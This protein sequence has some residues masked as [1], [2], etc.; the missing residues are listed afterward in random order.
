MTEFLTEQKPNNGPE[1]LS[2]KGYLF[3]VIGVSLII[4][5]LAGGVAGFFSASFFSASLAEW[6][7]NPLGLAKKIVSRPLN[8]NN[9]NSNVNGQITPPPAVQEEE[10][11]TTAAV[12]KVSPAVVSIVVTK[13]VRQYYNVSGPNSLFDDFF[14]SP[15]DNFFN[16]SQPT[17]PGQTEKKK[18]GGG[19]GFIISSDGLIVTN[20]HV[21]ADTEAEYSIIRSDGKTYPAQVVARDPV[22]DLAFLKI[23]GDN[24]P[25]AVL[26]DSAKL[27]VGQTVIAIGFALGEYSNTVTKGIISGIGRDIV[28]SGGG[29]ASEKLEG[30]IQTDAAIN[31]G[32]SGGPLINLAGEVIGINTAI[33]QSGQLI[34]F[35]IPVNNIKQVVK[36][37]KEKGKIVRAYLGVRYSV[38]TKELAQKNN[39][40]Y[41]YGALVVRGQA[42]G[43][44]A[45]IPASPADKAGLEENDIILQVDGVKLD[46]NKSLAQEVA[47]HQPGDKLNL[48][49]AHDGQE[50]IVQ[51]TLEEYPN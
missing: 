41:D 50:K 49:V 3:L 31:P 29:V 48:K 26:G 9:Q 27:K 12:A 33:N 42:S 18:I 35:A 14:N 15:F 11:S 40:K 20:K 6:L 23:A 47:K 8:L 43:E 4:G 21:V 16:Q 37:V 10:N 5:G 2:V 19:T 51:V 32:N 24:L 28:A 17:V 25:T 38:I 46:E 36:T 7:N 45:V 30:V 34:G 22:N 39:L 13:E 1:K 44:L